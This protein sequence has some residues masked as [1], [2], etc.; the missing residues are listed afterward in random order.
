[1]NT[2]WKKTS[3]GLVMT[4]DKRYESGAKT[5][6]LNDT[7]ESPENGQLI[8]F[9]KAYGSLLGDELDSVEIIKVT[10]VSANN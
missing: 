7:V 10:T 8:S 9:G 1:M 6:R 3:I 5:Y 4:N 2:T